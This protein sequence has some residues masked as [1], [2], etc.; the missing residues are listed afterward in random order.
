MYATE[1]HPQQLRCT[2]G[3]SCP[4]PVGHCLQLSQLTRGMVWSGMAWHGMLRCIAHL[5]ISHIHH[6]RRTFTTPSRFLVRRPMRSSSQ[7]QMVAV[8]MFFRHRLSFL[9]FRSPCRYA[10]R[11]RHRVASLPLERGAILLPP[12][13]TRTGS[14]ICVERYC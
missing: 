14:V 10:L 13:G 2:A 6:L 4:N 9:V 7:C 5:V 11:L 3:V 8:Y 1:V 12:A